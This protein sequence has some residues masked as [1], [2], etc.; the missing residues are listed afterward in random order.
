M[1]RIATAVSDITVIT[2]DN[3]RNEPREKI[4]SEILSGAKRNSNYKVIENRKD[5][6][7]YALALAKE[8]DTLLLAGKGH[9][10]YEITDNTKRHF[11]EKEIIKE[12][13]ESKC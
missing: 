9:E 1:G 3:P 10:D 13:F 6:I 11:C 5:A 8:G 12:F 7:R 2:S 4:I